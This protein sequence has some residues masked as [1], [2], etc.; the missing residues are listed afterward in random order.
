MRFSNSS[1]CLSENKLRSYSVP[2]VISVNFAI[3]VY[4]SLSFS[5]YKLFVFYRM[6]SITH[7]KIINKRKK[8]NDIAKKCRSYKK[9]YFE[10]WIIYIQK[11]CC[12]LI[13]KTALNVCPIISPCQSLH[14]HHLTKSRRLACCCPN[15]QPN[16]PK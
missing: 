11:Q 7:V 2:F 15:R 12:L 13:Q 3:I 9:K 1:I 10:Q 8:F 6:T 14:F 4:F 5:I 16:H